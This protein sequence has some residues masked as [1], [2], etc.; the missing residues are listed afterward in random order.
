MVVGEAGGGSGCSNK[1]ELTS[2]SIAGR[3]TRD[4]CH[5]L[6][7]LAVYAVKPLPAKDAFQREA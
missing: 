5:K 1:F 3:Y 7:T 4:K 2:R 6:C